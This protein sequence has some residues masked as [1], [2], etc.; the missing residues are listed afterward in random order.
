MEAAEEARRGLAGRSP[1]LV[2]VF[3]TAGHDQESLM[4]GVT[5]V[6]GTE[7]VSGCSAEGVI[8]AAGSEEVSHA[9]AVMAIASD[10]LTFHTYSVPHFG[11]RSR[12]A[13]AQLAEELAGVA[14]GRGLL[15]LFPDG[16]HGNCRELIASIE[17]RLDDVPRIVGGTA[18]DMLSFE[19]TYQYHDGAVRSDSLSAVLIE[20]DFEAE[21]LVSHGCDLIGQEHTVTKADDCYVYEIDGRPAWSLFKT[22]LADD[23]DTLEAMHLAHMILAEHVDAGDDATAAIEHFAPRVPV[24]LDAAKGALYFAAGLATGTTVQMGLRNADKVVEHAEAVA[25]S[26]VSRRSGQSPLL[27][28]QLDCAGRGRLLFEH[29]AS[30]S[31]V[32]P[33]RRIVGEDVPWIG[34]HTYGEIAPVGPSTLFHNYTGV[35]CALYSRPSASDG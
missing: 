25:R 6:L 21:L 4:A 16:I 27:V 32:D 28:M 35:L 12:A 34:L 9:V 30:E 24:S 19:R 17:E 33:V 20:G 22:Y 26:L 15:L 31:M 3:A 18:G 23:A 10:D 5:E 29:R 11:E 14:T 13:G 2:L 1:S 8:T 7:N